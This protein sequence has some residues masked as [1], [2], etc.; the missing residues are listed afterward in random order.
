MIYLRTFSCLG[1]FLM[2]LLLGLLPTLRFE[3]LLL[4]FLLLADLL[5]RRLDWLLWT[6]GLSGDLF[7]GGSLLVLGGGLLLG[8]CLSSFL[9]RWGLSERLRLR[10]ALLFFLL[11]AGGVFLSM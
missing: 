9:E 2:F 3:E 10:L 7:L 6:E 5:S 1:D 4:S 8:C 11:R